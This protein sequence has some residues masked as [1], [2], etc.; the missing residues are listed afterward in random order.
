M[1]GRT[2]GGANA[3][4][5]PSSFVLHNVRLIDGT[6]QVLERVDIQIEAGRIRT[7]SSQSVQGGPR[8]KRG[9][10]IDRA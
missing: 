5:V 6:G 3:N 1:V 4:P 7:V 8:R 10:G 9:R 2:S